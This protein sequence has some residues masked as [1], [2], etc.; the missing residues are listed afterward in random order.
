[1]RVYTYKFCLVVSARVQK[2]VE[3][4]LVFSHRD[5]QSLSAPSA[6]QFNARHC[7]MDAELCILEPDPQR[8]LHPEAVVCFKEARLFFMG[9]EMINGR[10]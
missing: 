7:C 1:M 8:W 6:A 4:C 2:L 10:S 3:S 5:C 9:S